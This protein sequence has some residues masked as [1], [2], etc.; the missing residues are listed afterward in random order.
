MSEF[1]A[2]PETERGRA[3]F[4]ELLWVHGMLRRDL[5]TV[6]RLATEVLEGKPAGELQ[7]EISELQ[8]NGPLWRL[9]VNCLHYC[10]FVEG[11]HG[12]EDA[13][14]FPWLRRANPAIAPAVER[15]EAE[16]RQVAGL[17][18]EVEASASSLGDADAEEPRRRVSDS[19]TALGGLLL[20]HLAFE[21]EQIGPTIRRL[22]A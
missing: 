12:L 17:L 21:E 16:H 14:V 20:A 10:R 6:Q 2:A 22:D 15:L 11:H 7:A 19:L 13:A 5:E 3:L 1:E 9:K 8:T 4:E 18:D